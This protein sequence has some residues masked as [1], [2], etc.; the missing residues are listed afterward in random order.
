[1]A[2]PMALKVTRTEG[3]TED[4]VLARLY[5]GGWAQLGVAGRL[6]MWAARCGWEAGQVGGWVRL[7]GCPSVRACGWVGAAGCG[8]GAGQVDG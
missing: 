8:W 7:G 3:L 5:E 2:C 6:A 4:A 1:M